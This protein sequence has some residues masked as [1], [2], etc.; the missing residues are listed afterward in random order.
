MFGNKCEIVGIFRF[1]NLRECTFNIKVSV[2]L[3]FLFRK[4]NLREQ[5]CSR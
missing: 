2:P 3:L 5:L 1:L 4:P